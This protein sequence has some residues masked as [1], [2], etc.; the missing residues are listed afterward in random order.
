MYYT[1]ST[2]SGD[3]SYTFLLD[4]E[5]QGRVAWGYPTPMTVLQDL[6][7]PGV[8]TVDSILARYVSG[9]AF[10]RTPLN[11]DFLNQLTERAMEYAMPGLRIGYIDD[12]RVAQSYGLTCGDEI[13]LSGDCK[14]C[15][16]LWQIGQAFQ[17]EN[18]WDVS[19]GPSKGQ[20]KVTADVILTSISDT[21]P[22]PEPSTLVLVGAGLLSVCRRLR[23]H[24]P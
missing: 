18:R 1:F 2:S 22:V 9:S 24:R 12:R 20:G 10:P 11:G 7:E 5:E 4:F 19:R 15:T 8:P 16:S 6:D 17:V 21:A 3:L 14:G 23:S 13:L